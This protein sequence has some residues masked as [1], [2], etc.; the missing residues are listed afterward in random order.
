MKGDLVSL[1][2][3]LV[4][5]SLT[6]EGSS[7]I[8]GGTLTIATGRT[9]TTQG[10]VIED[11]TTLVNNGTL[12]GGVTVRGTLTNGSYADTTVFEGGEID[13]NVTMQDVLV[14][15][16]DTSIFDV[17]GSVTVNG[18][19][20]VEQGTLRIESGT[21]VGGTGNFRVEATGTLSLQG[22]L[23]QNLV[24]DASGLLQGTG[25]INGDIVVSGQLGPGNSAG[26]LGVSGEI[27]LDPGSMVCIELGGPTSG[28]NGY[29]SINGLG[30]GV[31]RLGGTL[32]LMLIDGF[33]PTASDEFLILDNFAS[34]TGTF[35]N[36]TGNMFD[37]GFGRFQIEYSSS[38]VRLFNFTAVPEPSS[39]ALLASL[40]IPLSCTRRRS[41]VVSH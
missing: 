19:A 14:R 29:D 30:S 7:S 24:V 13:G 11:T 39:I 26:T 10:L 17:S 34:I 20:V 18:N 40:L 23:N 21:S 6:I 3:S 25:Q 12:G 35:D 32:E 38:S 9:L 41:S 22:T 15:T 5:Q 28:L 1:G 4:N 33:V 31:A 2:N 8:D 36:A 16:L 27:D 37:A